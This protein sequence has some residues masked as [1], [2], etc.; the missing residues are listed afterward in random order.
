MGAGTEGLGE[1]VEV[2]GAVVIIV[3]GFV[4]DVG[5]IAVAVGTGKGTVTMIGRIAGIAAVG[6]AAAAAA[7]EEDIGVGVMATVGAGAAGAATAVGTTSTAGLAIVAAPLSD[8]AT[9][10]NNFF[11]PIRLV[12]FRFAM[13]VGDQFAQRSAACISA[14]GIFI[15]FAL[16]TIQVGV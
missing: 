15:Y 16:T 13:L 4:A 6:A 2:M 14:V 7:E 5:A 1:A 11:L 9:K 8:L 3:E 10:F 12:F